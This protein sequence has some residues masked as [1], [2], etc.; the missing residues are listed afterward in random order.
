MLILKEPAPARQS[1]FVKAKSIREMLDGV[2][3]VGIL[4]GF[5]S[6]N[7]VRGSPPQR[8]GKRLKIKR[9]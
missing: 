9:K 5:D 8:D 3:R 2:I 7:H 4:L 1:V 6:P